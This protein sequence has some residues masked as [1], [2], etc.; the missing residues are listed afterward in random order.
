M[1]TNRFNFED[2]NPAPEEQP[3]QMEIQPKDM[4]LQQLFD[5][6]N[7]STTAQKAK[8]LAEVAILD[9]VRAAEAKVFLSKLPEDFN[10]KLN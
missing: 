3:E 4:T 1:K 9:N 2:F 8:A 10:P 5:V 7:K 6:V